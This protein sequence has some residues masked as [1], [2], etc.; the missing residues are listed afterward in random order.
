VTNADH[1]FRSKNAGINQNKSRITDPFDMD[2]TSVTIF[3]ESS[4]KVEKVQYERTN[5]DDVV[6]HIINE[7]SLDRKKDKLKSLHEDIDD[8]AKNSEKSEKLSI[9]KKEKSQ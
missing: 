6:A 3:N 7:V 1:T 5:I 4:E 9:L 8:L 2:Y